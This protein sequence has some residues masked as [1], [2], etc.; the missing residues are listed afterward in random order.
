MFPGPL[1]V[2]LAGRALEEGIWSLDTVQIRDFAIDKHRTVDDTP[3]GGGAGMVLRVD[4]LA[5]A[6][7]HARALHPDSPIL[8]MTPRGKPLTQAR[9]RELA[10]GPGVIV[11]CGRFEGFDERIFAGRAIEEVSIGDI[12]LSGGEPAA[13][14]LLDACIRLLPGVMGAPSSG[15]EESFENGLLEYPHYTRPTTW[16]GRTIPEVLRSGDHAKIAAWRQ[17]Q[18][19][20]DTR[21]RRPDLWERHEGARVQSASGARRK[22][23]DLDQ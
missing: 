7:D 23:K 13:L 21:S 22:K 1:G 17:H 16:E 2:S 20:V 8:A 11:L 19:E 14:M 9:V 12:V 4:V 10:S 3:A 15:S 6:I 18:A 5:A